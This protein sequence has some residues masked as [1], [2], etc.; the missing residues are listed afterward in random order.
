MRSGGEHSRQREVLSKGKRGKEL[1]TVEE[2][3]AGGQGGLEAGA[4]AQGPAW[5]GPH[6]LGGSSTWG[7]SGVTE[8]GGRTQDGSYFQVVLTSL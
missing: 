2:Q 8:A 6:E 5:A 7:S 4:A 3:K 1:G